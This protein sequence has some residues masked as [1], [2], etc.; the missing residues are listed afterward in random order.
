MDITPNTRH[1]AVV[2]HLNAGIVKTAWTIYLFKNGERRADIEVAMVENPSKIYTF[3]F[4]N[5]GGVD[6]A[7]WHLVVFETAAATNK[8]VNSWRV[9]NKVTELGVRQLRSDVLSPL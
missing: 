1:Y 6:E 2:A 5:D 9:K 4:V 8:Y 3:S 7:Q